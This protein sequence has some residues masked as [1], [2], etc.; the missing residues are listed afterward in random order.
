MRVAFFSFPLWYNINKY[1]NNFINMNTNTKI[2]SIIVSL[3]AVFV[4]ASSAYAAT[5]TLSLSNSGSGDNVQITVNGDPNAG[6][7]LYYTKLGSGLQLPAIGTTSSS[8]YFS[9]IVSTAT[10]GVSSNS[11]VHVIVNSQASQDVAWPYTSASTSSIALNQTGIVLNVGQSSTITANGSSSLYMLN[12]SNPPIANVNI[13]GNQ[14]IITGNSYGQAV[15]TICPQGTS[16]SCPSIYVTVQ[17]SGASSLTFSQSSVTI[18][19]GQ[20]FPVTISGGT[21]IYTILNNSNSGAVQASLNGATITLSTSSTSGSSSITV[22]SSDQSSCGIIN[23]TVGTASS[24]SIYF[25]QTS[26]IITVGQSMTISISGGSSSNYYVSSNSSPSIVQASLSGSTLTLY[27]ITSGSSVVTV[28]SST[29]SCSSL[30]ATSNYVSSGGTIT[31]SQ[32]SVSALVGQTVS[33]TVS[34]GSTPYSVSSN[35]GNVFQTSFNG[36]ILNVYGVSAG[37]SSIN[38]CSAGGGCVVLYVTVGGYSSTSQISLSQTSISLSVGQTATVSVSGTGGYYISGNTNSSVATA[39]LNGNSISLY[40]ANTGTTNVSLCQ[41]GGQCVALYVTVGT[42]SSTSQIT[43]GQSSVS[44]S[45]GQTATVSVSGSGG[46]YISSSTNLSVASASVSGSSV[47]IYGANTGTT[48]VSICQT[49]GQCAIIYVTV[50]STTSSATNTVFLKFSQNNPT[51]AVNQSVTILIAG[52]TQGSYTIPY[53]SSTGVAQASI[54]GSILTV[55]GKAS[56]STVIVA[57]DSSS[58][59][60]AVLVT[61]KATTSTSSNESSGSGGSKYQF[62]RSLGIGDTGDDVAELQQRLTAEGVYSGPVTGTYGNLTASAVKLYQKSNKI[63]QTG[64]VGPVTADTL[65]K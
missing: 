6:V 25:S 46:Y 41:T 49:G 55:S 24:S 43:L 44:I 4:L 39:S 8:G 35:T 26:P 36:N 38:V 48:N 15:I 61:V 59:C 17:N 64:T 54:S 5:P 10:L 37:S 56:G 42:S 65:N 22:C 32:T 9:T 50:S 58:N 31:L 19:S 12:N 47:S 2:F 16:T 63:K 7:L 40:G 45:L 57:C 34:G 23:V 30:T 28:C 29:G 52:G 11:A 21:G 1:L 27:G 18:S 20:N 53:N 33:I 62:L 3:F 14:I 13:S 51:V 60:G